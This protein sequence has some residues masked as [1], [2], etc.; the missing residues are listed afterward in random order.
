MRAA[1]FNSFGGPEVLEIV[2]V[3]DPH[4]GPQQIRIAVRAAGVSSTDA[5]MRSGALGGDLPQT[6][7]RDV[8]GV[9]EALGEGVRS[10]AIG[11]RV[12][13]SSD[14]GAGA[15]ELALVT[16][17]A[18]IPRE[19]GFVDA[20]A[21]PS[22]LETATRALD[23]LSVGAGTVLLVNGASGAIGGAVV[24]L[25]VARGMRV[26]GTAGPAN[27]GHVRSLGAEAI[28]YGDGL[29]D[30]VRALAPN[31]VDAALDVAGNGVLAELVELASGRAHVVTIAD[32]VGAK[33]H[34]VHFSKGEDGRAFH[35]YAEIAPLIAAG[36]F[37]LPVGRTFRL[38]DIADAHRA[39][40]AGD[41]RGKI[42]L[43]VG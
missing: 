37:W 11:D 4:P 6:T 33:E 30:R 9:V 23:A 19:L 43:L 16:H 29:V 10:V 17:F 25:A 18:P 40:E 26:I 41:V 15:A 42:V 38:D 13:G 32:F 3:P 5:K 14:D 21:L 22:T 8:A 2:R 1:R 35:A 36:R 27:Q 31:G 20:A 34:G 39:V 24:Q 7:G 12:F 28:V